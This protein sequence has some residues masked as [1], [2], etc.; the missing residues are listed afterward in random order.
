MLSLFLAK[1]HGDFQ[2]KIALGRSQNDLAAVL[3]AMSKYVAADELYEQCYQARKRTHGPK[4][5][6]PRLPGGCRGW[7]TEEIV[8][9]W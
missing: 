5:P 7:I 1:F 8:E 3:A 6:V 9:P 2:A 4:H